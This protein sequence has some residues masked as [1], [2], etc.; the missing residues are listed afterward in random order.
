MR[1][2]TVQREKS[3]RDFRNRVLNALETPK[4]TQSKLVSIINSAFFLWLLSATLVTFCGW[5]ITNYQQCAKQADDISERFQE[6]SAGVGE[7]LRTLMKR[8]S[9]AASIQSF[10][11]VIKSG[12]D[13]EEPVRDKKL[14]Q[15]QSMLP[16]LQ[17]EVDRS[18]WT[19]FEKPD[20][21]Y[22]TESERFRAAQFLEKLV[23]K[24][25]VSKKGFK[26]D[27]LT[28]EAAQYAG[29]ISLTLYTVYRS[30]YKRAC[31]FKDIVKRN[32]LM[33][34]VKLVRAVPEPGVHP[35]LDWLNKQIYAD[36]M[37]GP[38][39]QDQ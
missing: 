38:V 9:R 21:I 25:K 35:E 39:E 11:E 8:A 27:V 26:L 18:A 34:P 4:T 7:G 23:S 5:Y 14:S 19:D 22:P 15:L 16:S 33:E 20:W 12:L 32:L 37:P 28:N 24:T 17:K 31:S 30:E 36:G 3:E 6:V 13:S 29:R 10:V 2:T 1:E